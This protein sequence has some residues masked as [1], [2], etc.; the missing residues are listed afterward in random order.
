AIYRQ[1]EYAKANIPMLPV[2]HGIKF[3]KLNVVLYSFLLLAV[4]VMPFITGLCGGIYLVSSLLLGIIFIGYSIKLYYSDND[5][6]ALHTF[7]YSIVYL[8]ALFIALFIDKLFFYY[9]F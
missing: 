5:K 6:V 3:T 1:K 4:S 2:T 9:Y 7:G 8:I